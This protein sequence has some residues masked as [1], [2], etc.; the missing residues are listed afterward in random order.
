MWVERGE[1]LEPGTVARAILLDKKGRVLL[2]L[3][4]RGIGVGQWALIGGKPEEGENLKKAVVREVW[5]EVGISFR[6]RRYREIIGSDGVTSDKWFIAYFWGRPR[7]TNINLN[8]NE[9]KE[10]GFFTLEEIIN[11]DIAFDHKR[12]IFEFFANFSTIQKGR[13]FPSLPQATG[14]F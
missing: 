4:K 10:A 7:S 8:Q 11:M 14:K 3:R 9:V 1:C 2:G 13:Q 12:V 5:E 6:P